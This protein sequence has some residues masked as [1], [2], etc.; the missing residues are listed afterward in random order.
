MGEKALLASTAM[1]LL[2]EDLNA[3]SS[4]QAIANKN[5]VDGQNNALRTQIHHADRRLR[6]GIAGANAQ[7]HWHQPLC[8]QVHGCDC[9]EEGMMAKV[10]LAIVILASA[11]TVRLC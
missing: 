1:R 8:R 7:Q 5:Y 11:I 3:S 9:Y 6:A 2:V 10:R 4:G